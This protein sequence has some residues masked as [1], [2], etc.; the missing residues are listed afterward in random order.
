MRDATERSHRTTVLIVEDDRWL[1]EVLANLLAEDGYNVVQ[2]SNGESGLRLARHNTCDA[3]LLDLTLPELRGTSVLR[4]LK[5]DPATRDIPVLIL[6]GGWQAM[7]HEDAEKAAAVMGKPVD[8][9]ALLRELGQAV[10]AAPPAQ[11]PAVG[12]V[13]RPHASGAPAA[14]PLRGRLHGP[15]G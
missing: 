5:R 3:I 2:A 12:P 7:D 15:G 9:L 14:I 10:A 8:F 11:T 13:R 4:E 1:R 6:S